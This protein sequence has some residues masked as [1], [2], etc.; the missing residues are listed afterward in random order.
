MSTKERRGR[1][2]GWRACEDPPD[3]RLN[4]AGCAVQLRIAPDLGL[5]TRPTD[6]ARLRARIGTCFRLTAATR[7]TSLWLGAWTTAQEF[8][9]AG[10]P[11]IGSDTWALRYTAIDTSPGDS[12]AGIYQVFNGTPRYLIGSHIGVAGG[13]AYNY[14]RRWDSTTSNFATANTVF[15]N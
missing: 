6:A 12:G 1:T 15:P 9:G 3:V 5:P 13:D 10:T 8:F 7:W 14:G 11:F 2:P 4:D